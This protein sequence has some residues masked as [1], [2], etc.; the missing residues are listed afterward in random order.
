M[1]LANLL[2]TGKSFFNGQGSP[3]YRESR[4]AFVP[5]FNSDKNPFTPKAVTE[6]KKNAPASAPV[7]A[8]VVEKPVARSARPARATSWVEKINP[9]RAPE[10][11]KSFGRAEQPELSLD[12]VKVL[13]NDL[14]EA[15]IERVP[16]K[17]LTLPP[18]PV[19]STVGTWEVMANAS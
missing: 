12:T 8:P 13:Q 17:S 4:R 14:S 2:A 1:T 5:K 6:K 3:A 9:F 7:T 11:V 18:T 10:P 19:K 15:D 16:A